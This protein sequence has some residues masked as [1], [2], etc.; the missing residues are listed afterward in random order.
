[1]KINLNQLKEGIEAKILSIE[2]NNRDRERLYALGLKPGKN[3]KLFHVSPFND[4][5]IFKIDENKIMLRNSE[6]SRIFVETSDDVMDLNSAPN[7]FYKIH[8]FNG[9]NF[10]SRKMHQKDLSE[11]EKIHK[12]NNHQI[13]IIDKNKNISLGKG[14]LNKILVTPVKKGAE[15]R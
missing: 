8:R 11:G 9:G 10:F 3:I 15:K 6:A 12:E 5:K 2:T 14:E 4:P 1:M 13:L 7:G